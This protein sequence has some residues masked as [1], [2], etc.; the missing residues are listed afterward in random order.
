MYS[1]FKEGTLQQQCLASQSWSFSLGFICFVLL[2][3]LLLLVLLSPIQTLK[4]F[5][6]KEKTS[7]KTMS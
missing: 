1:I 6:A 7:D 3:L 4:D 2:R 5:L